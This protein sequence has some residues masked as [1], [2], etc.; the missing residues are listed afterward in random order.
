MGTCVWARVYVYVCMCMCVCVCV[1][2]YVCMYNYNCT[3][4]ICKEAVDLS[5][6][7][8]SIGSES[9][10]S[11]QNFSYLPPLIA[12]AP[13]PPGAVFHTYALRAY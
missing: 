1:Y 6:A 12:I 9:I 13:T 2:V 11:Q 4:Y 10:G 8:V 5:I 3:V 7:S